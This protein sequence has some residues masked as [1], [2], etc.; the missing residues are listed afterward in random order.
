MAK[1][2]RGPFRY[3][4]AF[5]A[6]AAAIGATTIPVVG[7]G[8]VSVLFLAIFVSAGTAASGRAC[9]LQAW[10]PSSLQSVQSGRLILHRGGSWR[11]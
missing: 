5:L 3:A 10:S 2:M 9:S 6:V 1:L 4:I 8:L 11:F 7:R